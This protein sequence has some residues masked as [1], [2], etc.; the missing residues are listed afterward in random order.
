MI[1][2]RHHGAKEW[3]IDWALFTI[4]DYNQQKP[5]RC[6]LFVSTSRAASWHGGVFEWI[7]RCE[8]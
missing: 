3:R 4:R 6:M 1:H 7:K 5:Y 8:T 2:G